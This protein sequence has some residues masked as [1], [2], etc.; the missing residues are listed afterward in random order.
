MKNSADK[1]QR[2][3]FPEYGFVVEAKSLEEAQEKAKKIISKK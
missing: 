3:N 2:Y 1:M